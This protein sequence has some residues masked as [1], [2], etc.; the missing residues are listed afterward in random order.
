MVADYS[1]QPP[2]HC[3]PAMI[4]TKSLVPPWLSLLAALLSLLLPVAAQ[5]AA[6]IESSGQ[7]DER[8]GWWREARFGLFIHW[9]IWSVAAGTVHGQQIEDPSDPSCLI[10]AVPMP[11]EEYLEYAQ[12]STPRGSTPTNGCGW[13]NRPA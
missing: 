12:R 1:S 11:A 2:I 7:R 9:G 8:M 5:P 4:R 13:R 6:T 3:K 10:T